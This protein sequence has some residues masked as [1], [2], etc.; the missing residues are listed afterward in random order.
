MDKQSK[1]QEL[2]NKYQ[3]KLA[4]VKQIVKEEE[5]KEA[6]SAENNKEGA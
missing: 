1:I 6:S 3:G 2:L 5:A 4:P